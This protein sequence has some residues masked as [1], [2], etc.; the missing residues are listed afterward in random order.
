MYLCMDMKY[1][2][3]DKVLEYFKELQTFKVERM[4]RILISKNNKEFQMLKNYWMLYGKTETGDLGPWH[5]PV[6]NWKSIHPEMFLI[7]PMSTEFSLQ[8]DLFCFYHIVL[9]ASFS[10]KNSTTSIRAALYST[11]HTLFYF[12]SWR[13]ISDLF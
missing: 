5:P 13:F 6:D 12:S 4:R 3:N 11:A 8:K 10:L 9:K 1:I 2:E 7:P